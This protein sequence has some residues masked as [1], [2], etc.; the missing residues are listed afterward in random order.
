M[1]PKFVL[2][3]TNPRGIS[4]HSTKTND[5]QT[6]SLK[7]ICLN[8]FFFGSKNN[9]VIIIIAFIVNFIEIILLLH[10]QVIYKYNCVK[11]IVFIVSKQ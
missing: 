9:I 3:N 10:F 7:Q 2:P 8:N 4:K 11:R 5:L 1:P 6:F